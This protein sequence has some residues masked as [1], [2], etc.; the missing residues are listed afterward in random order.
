MQEIDTDSGQ[1]ILVMF[2]SAAAG[3]AIWGLVRR[4]PRKS[5]SMDPHRVNWPAPIDIGDAT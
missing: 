4:L 2:L 3:L 1:V 5:Y